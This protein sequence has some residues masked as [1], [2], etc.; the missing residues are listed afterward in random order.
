MCAAPKW[1]NMESF[2]VFFRILKNSWE[3]LIW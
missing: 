3:V 2:L 1:V